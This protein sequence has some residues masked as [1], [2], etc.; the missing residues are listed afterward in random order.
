MSPN[1][2]LPLILCLVFVSA[3]RSTAQRG[4][5]TVVTE[6][7]CVAKNNAEDTALQGALDWACGQGGANCNPIQQGGPCSDPTDIQKTASY[8][9]NDYYLKNGMTDD[10]CSFSNNAALTSL[11]P[12]YGNC[13]F[14]SS[15]TVN[16]AS[17]SESTG[18]LG[19]GPDY[20]DLSASHRIAQSWLILAL[21]FHSF[22]YC[23]DLP[24]SLV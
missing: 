13:K 12:S 10:A 11:N 17:I 14:P 3:T 4:G 8:A 6:L 15:K 5:G 7:W 20:T 1:L 23:K 2:F 22:C 19:V 24:T 21:F 16:N 18:T 9:F